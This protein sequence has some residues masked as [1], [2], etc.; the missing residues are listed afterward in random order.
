MKTYEVGETSVCY[1]EIRKSNAL[2]DPA[3]S[4][5]VTIYKPDG[6]AETITS[7]TKESTGVYSY[8][9]QTAGKPLGKY[10]VFYT[11]TDGSKITTGRDY[12]TLEVV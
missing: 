7:M 12:F 6:T 2:Y 3:T 11:V 9:Y 10:K 1:L 4:I 5:Q 8:D